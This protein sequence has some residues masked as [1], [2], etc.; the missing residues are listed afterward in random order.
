SPLSS[1]T[2]F[3]Y[4]TLFRSYLIM[5][6]TLQISNGLALLA[7]IFINYL[8]NTGKINNT[9]IGEVSNQYNS[10]F[11]PAGYAFS[12]WGFIYLLLLGLDR[13]STR[14]NSSHV[15]ISY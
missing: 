3:P 11:T 15:K 14:L 8:S 2:L 1:S 6:K 5:K 9:T 13:K 10:L 4:T 12:I 7:T